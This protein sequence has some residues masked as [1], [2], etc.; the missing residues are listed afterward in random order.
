MAQLVLTADNEIDENCPLLGHY[1]ASSGNILP[2]FRDDLSV[3]TSGVKKPKESLLYQYEVSTGKSVINEYGTDG[4][5][6][7]VGKKLPKL[8]V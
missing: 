7:T 6:L 8:A 3:L 4:L 2:A 1:V 5:F